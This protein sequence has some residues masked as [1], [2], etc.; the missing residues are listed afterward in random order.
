MNVYQVWIQYG[1]VSFGAST[2]CGTGTEN[3]NKNYFENDVNYPISGYPNGYSRVSAY[4]DFI[5]ETTGIV[6]K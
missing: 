1:V 4:L 3:F 6:Y 2:G 5:T